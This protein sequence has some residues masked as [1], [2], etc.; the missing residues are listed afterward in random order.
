MKVSHFAERRESGG[1]RVTLKFSTLTFILSLSISTSSTHQHSLHLHLLPPSFIYFNLYHSSLV[2]LPLVFLLIFVLSFLPF[3]ALVMPPPPFPLS[4]S[5]SG[6]ISSASRVV[7]L[8]QWPITQSHCLLSGTDRI[9]RICHLTTHSHTHSVRD[10]CHLDM[11]RQ[12]V[13]SFLSVV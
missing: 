10:T 12:L 3:T 1:F 7:L 4:L 8:S 5:D 11:D 9:S 6:S 2:L 13:G